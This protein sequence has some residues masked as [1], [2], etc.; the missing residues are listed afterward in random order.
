MNKLEHLAKTLSRTKR[1][2]YENY[3]INRLYNLLNDFDIKPVSQQYVKRE[4]GKYALID[5]YFPQLNIGIEVDEIHHLSQED[6]DRLRYD[7]IINSIRSYQEIRIPI[8]SSDMR[9][10]LNL[11]EIEA[12][13]SNAVDIIKTKRATINNFIPWDDKD[14]IERA[15][16]KGVIF[17]NDN[18]IF[19]QE[20]VRNFFGKKGTVRQSYYTIKPNHKIWCPGLAIKNGEKYI[21][22]NKNLKFINILSEDGKIVYEYLPNP[23]GH[24][25]DKFNRVIFLK[26]KHTILNKQVYKFIGVFK[27]REKTEILNFTGKDEEYAVYDL[28]CETVTP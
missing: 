4:N 26:M 11:E 3:V 21:P 16:E 1:K 27:E 14:D 2:D 22:Y 8:Y 24:E 20:Q 17:V 19:T 15:L 7:E 5:L 23:N 28:I 13:I 6:E 10:M 12:N 25:K 18:Y 9:K